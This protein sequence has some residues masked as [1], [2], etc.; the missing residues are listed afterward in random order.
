MKAQD[1]LNEIFDYLYNG[2]WTIGTGNGEQSNEVFYEWL[3][4][5][6]GKP[7]K[8]FLLKLMANF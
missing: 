1:L 5:D 8:R 3:K 4:R 2:R 7:W 6:F